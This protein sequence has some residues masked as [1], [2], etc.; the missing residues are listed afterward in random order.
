MKKLKQFAINY[1]KPI[2]IKG[3]V[4][5]LTFITLQTYYFFNFIIKIFIAFGTIGTTD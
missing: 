3:I 4:Y 1:L 2:K 5:I